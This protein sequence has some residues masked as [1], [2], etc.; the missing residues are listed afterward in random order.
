MTLQSAAVIVTGETYDAIIQ[1]AN[2]PSSPNFNYAN[3]PEAP[4][5]SN[6]DNR[7]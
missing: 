4:S 2:T 3:E 1:L 5:H 7:R 6:A